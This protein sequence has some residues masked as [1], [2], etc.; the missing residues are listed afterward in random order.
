M[1]L[2]EEGILNQS[3]IETNYL[4][5]LTIDNHSKDYKV[6][7]IRLDCLYY[8]DQNDRIATWISQYKTERG[9]E[10]IDISEHDEYNNLIHKFV[11]ESNKSSIK[12][13]QKNIELIGQQEYGVV[14]TDGR[15]IDGNRRFTCLRNIQNETGQTQYFEA[16]I[17]K[18]DIHNNAK[19]IKMLELR[20]QHGADKQ[21]D[22][23]PIEKLV[24]IYNDIIEHQLLTP[25]EYANSIQGSKSVVLTDMERSK[26]M[27]EFLDFINAPKQFHL[28][29]TMDINDPLKELQ[30]ILKKCVDEDRK[31]DLKNIVF[32]NV[33]MQPYGDMTRYIRKINKVAANEIM[34]DGYIEEQIDDTEA[35][36][37][38]V[39]KYDIVNEKLIREEI[40]S[41][42]ELRD[43]FEK[44]TEKWVAKADGD[45][46]RNFPAKQSEKAIETLE[47]I[48]VNILN[49]LNEQQKDQVRNNLDSLQNL[50]DLIRS[51]LDV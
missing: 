38:I 41:N 1:N 43:K 51:E 8:N 26:L 29:R 50:I 11:T 36:C 30:K 27:I 15:V 35:V 47:T 23:D 20:L 42:Q 16:V 37:N 7:K 34:L 19:Q 5:K 13:T 18:H 40:R 25:E 22:Y 44:I 10:N 24:G 21:V 4:K 49:K 32:A 9:I 2:L 48:D 12:K 46:T 45:A 3:V 6:Y 28:A 31:E 33:L 14:L 39:E 17:L